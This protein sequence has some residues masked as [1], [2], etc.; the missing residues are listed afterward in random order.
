[1]RPLLVD[2]PLHFTRGRRFDASHQAAVKDV[3]VLLSFQPPWKIV[4][5]KSTLLCL[6]QSGRWAYFTLGG[7]CVGDLR[8]QP[9]S[10]HPV[11][12]NT[13]YFLKQIPL[14]PASTLWWNFTVLY[15]FGTQNNYFTASNAQP[16]R[17]YTPISFIDFL[18]A[19]LGNAHFVLGNFP[20]IIDCRFS[21]ARGKGKEHE[22]PL[23]GSFSLEWHLVPPKD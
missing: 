15:L 9:V 22:A 6:P 17:F 3:S 5:P 11:Q 7:C 1:M 23:S 20:K 2:C 13:F 4:K 14:S 18:S 12:M 10:I 8:E 16:P 19:Y 21:P